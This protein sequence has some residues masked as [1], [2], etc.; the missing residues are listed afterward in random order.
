MDYANKPNDYY[1]N[2]RT[3][4]QAFC[5]PNAKKILDVGCG[6]G[7]MAQQLKQKLNAEVWGVEYTETEALIAK[8]RLDKVIVS[9]VEQSLDEL[10]DSYFDAIYFNDVLEH[11]TYPIEVLK[12]MKAKLS[13]DGVIISSIPN[14]R[15]HR[16]FKNYIFNKDWKYE[17]S[18]VLDYTHFRFFTSKSIQRMHEEAGYQILQHQGI[19]KTKSLKPYFYNLLL[20]FTAS[21]MFYIQFATVAR[22]I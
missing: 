16:V 17:K 20:L 2:F 18:G 1:E 10:P 13:A 4:M 3:E 6:R 11:L 22:K 7:A 12:R 8:E 5:P 9:A 19:N 21:D 15:Y 14:V